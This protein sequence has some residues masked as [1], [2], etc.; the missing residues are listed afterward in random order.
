[1][2]SK[3]GWLVPSD[4]AAK[5]YPRGGMPAVVRREL[6][7]LLKQKKAGKY[8]EPVSVAFCYAAL[9]QKEQTLRWLETAL[10]EHSTALDEFGDQPA[11]DFVRSDPRWHAIVAKMGLPE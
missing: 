5:A 10:A 11:F 1:M 4:A 3:P 6:D 9:G 7:E 8:V 2:V